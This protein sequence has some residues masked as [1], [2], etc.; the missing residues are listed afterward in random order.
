MTTTTG[1][2]TIVTDAVLDE[3]TRTDTDWFDRV[4]PITEVV[5]VV[6]AVTAVQ[7]AVTV[8]DV[9]E[10]E[11]TRVE[12]RALVAS[13]HAGVRAP[14]TTARPIL[15]RS[16]QA[17]G[18][19][20]WSWDELEAHPARL[21]FVLFVALTTMVVVITARWTVP[22]VYRTVAPAPTATAQPTPSPRTAVPAVH[23]PHPLVGLDHVRSTPQAH[24]TGPTASTSI[25]PSPSVAA[26]GGG[27]STPPVQVPSGPPST[28]P[29]VP[30]VAS[31]P[32]GPTGGPTKTSAPPGQPKP[33]GSP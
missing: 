5:E 1:P 33:T 7:D 28:G 3:R 2:S 15:R 32:P 29:A 19:A 26:P 24:R 9:G 13:A 18:W 27:V 6:P 25:T 20:R 14:R 11:A 10:G 21:A 23:I 22:I 8:V 17:T 16:S 31:S 30:P 4:L 12:N